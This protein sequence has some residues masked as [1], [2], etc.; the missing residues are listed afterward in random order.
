MEGTSHTGGS[1][2]GTS[3]T[4]GSME[5]TSHPGGSLEGMSY[6]ASPPWHGGYVIHS[7]PP[8]AWRVCHIQ[9]PTEFGCRYYSLPSPNYDTTIWVVAEA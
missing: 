5:G 8:L 1:M 6:T 2:T 9:P 7:L 4:G 3:H